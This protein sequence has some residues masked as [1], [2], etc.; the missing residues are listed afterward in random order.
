MTARRGTDNPSNHT[1][2]PRAREL[3]Q[4]DQP[5]GT[6]LTPELRRR[7]FAEW[8]YALCDREYGVAQHDYSDVGGTLN[9]K[10]GRV[11]KVA[12]VDGPPLITVEQAAESLPTALMD[13]AQKRAEVGE[14]G[15]GTWW[16][17]GLSADVNLYDLA[18]V[19]FMRILNE[20]K[21]YQGPWRFGGNA[22][23]EFEQADVAPAPITMP[24]FKATIT[25][26]VPGPAHGPF[27]RF[28]QKE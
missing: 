17:L 19:H 3:P 23:L 26:R 6:A 28:L 4:D 5:E 22:L 27:G 9:L 21:R 2:E 7:L 12:F 15:A 10:D 18:N 13:E 11:V 16:T 1:A 20:H 14:L 25:F 8:L 24:T